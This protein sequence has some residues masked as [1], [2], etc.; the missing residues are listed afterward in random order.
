MLLQKHWVARHENGSITDIT[1][2]RVET[3]I[4]VHP[5]SLGEFERLPEELH[6][7]LYQHLR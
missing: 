3:L 6:M 4:I 5:G 1:P 7:V 2:L